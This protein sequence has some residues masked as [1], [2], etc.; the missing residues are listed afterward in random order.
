MLT[1]KNLLIG[2]IILCNGFAGNQGIAQSASA[3]GYQLSITINAYKGQ[4]LYLGYHYGK[5]KALADSAMVKPNGTAVFTGANSLP[6]GIY[7]VVS[8]KKEILYELL[9][10][11]E[12]R[13][14][15]AVDSAQIAQV[16]FIGSKDNIDFQSY[17]RFVH[18]KGTAINEQQALLAKAQNKN[19]SALIT[20]K[21]RSLNTEI[22][23]YRSD[24]MGK[25][26]NSF[27]ATLFSALQE[28]QIPPAANH[29]KGVYDSTFAYNF[30]KSHYW[31]GISF[32]DA[33]LLRTPFFEA[34]LERYY[35]DLVSPE[36]DSIK[37]EIDFMLA[38]A[39][40]EKE[41]YKYLLTH[42]VQQYIN[43]QYMGQDAVF[44]HIFEKY[45]NGKNG[46][47]W[48]TEK[49]KKY[50]TDR[51]YSLMANL[52]G[53]PAWDMT[54]TDTSGKIAPLYEVGAPFTVI[55][56]WD[57][58]CSH[59]KEMVPHLDSMFQHKWKAQGIKIYGVMTEGGKENWLKYI[60]ENNL[61]GWIHVYQTE[62]QRETERNSGKPGYRQL[63]D[64]YQTPVLYLLDEQKR[65][66]A[67]KLTY[68]QMDDLITIKKQKTAANR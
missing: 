22:L 29:P 31:D 55:C 30:F 8:P 21:S 67:K 52:I 32:S 27:L 6:G 15:M 56:F 42:F 34:R 24:F 66:I 33:R 41:M 49:Y 58:T 18:A 1:M 17:T 19:D 64:V 47:D 7:F 54:M 26:P 50:M 68:Q 23:N 36:P 5:I 48:F 12:Q 35:R 63:Y 45:I 46:V 13:F 57:P 40:P 51:A 65:I 53:N 9:I 4:F 38:R 62:E 10:D 60:R 43:P 39:M 16:K 28:P 3:K 20:G 2:I 59:C 25:N 14:S 37:K 44:V 11:K 61:T